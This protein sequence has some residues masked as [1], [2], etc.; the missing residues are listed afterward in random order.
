MST[1]GGTK[2]RQIQVCVDTP[3]TEGRAHFQALAAPKQP[4]Q[5]G[6]NS[7]RRVTRTHGVP[8]LTVNKHKPIRIYLHL[9]D[10]VSEPVLSQVLHAF[11]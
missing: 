2:A 11:S 10:A 4:C 6:F 8:H 5:V 7:V 1:R 3:C 9:G